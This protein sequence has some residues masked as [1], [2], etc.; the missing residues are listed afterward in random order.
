[1]AEIEIRDMRKGEDIFDFMIEE[2][3]KLNR[4]REERMKELGIDPK[5][6]CKKKSKTTRHPYT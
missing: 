1:M 2:N 5:T 4:Y 3:N 6:G